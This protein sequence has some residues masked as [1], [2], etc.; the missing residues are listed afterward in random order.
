MYISYIFVQKK[1]CT[2]DLKV[3]FQKTIKSDAPIPQFPKL[4]SVIVGPMAIARV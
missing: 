3:L 2:I 4:L 1:K